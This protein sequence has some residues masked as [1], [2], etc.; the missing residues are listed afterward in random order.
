MFSKHSEDGRRKSGTRTASS[1]N[2]NK[3]NIFIRYGNK[4]GFRCHKRA[5]RCLQTTYEATQD[6]LAVIKPSELSR[7]T[8]KKKEIYRLRLREDLLWLSTPDEW[9]SRKET[10]CWLFATIVIWPFHW[11]V[12]RAT[13][14]KNPPKEF[15]HNFSDAHRCFNF[16]TL[17]LNF[18]SQHSCSITTN[19]LRF[20]L[21]AHKYFCNYI[22]YFTRGKTSLSARI[23]SFKSRLLLN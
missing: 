23:I 4:L 16:S 20:R 6:F 3:T 19:N 21:I 12:G 10:L 13:E 8:R 18:F 9:T 22:K 1:L 17:R 2:S 7:R 15:S 5:P 14:P 11:T